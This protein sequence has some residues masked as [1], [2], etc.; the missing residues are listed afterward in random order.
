M[1]YLNVRIFFVDDFG[2]FTD[3]KNNSQFVLSVIK[4]TSSI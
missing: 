2:E 1:L 4:Q 3:I